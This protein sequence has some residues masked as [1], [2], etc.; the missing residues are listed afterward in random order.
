M[1][2]KA[3]RAAGMIPQLFFYVRNCFFFLYSY[4]PPCHSL[5]VF[6]HS[7]ISVVPVSVSYRMLCMITCQVCSTFRVR[8]SRMFLSV[9]TSPI[10]KSDTWSASLSPVNS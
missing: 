6:L 8:L 2:G 1:Y 10:R 9:R 4:P 5:A 7:G 3:E